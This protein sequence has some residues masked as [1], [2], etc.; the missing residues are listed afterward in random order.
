MFEFIVFHV[1]TSCVSFDYAVNRT[2]ERDFVIRDFFVP[3]NCVLLT[4]PKNHETSA[5]FHSLSQVTIS[6][7]II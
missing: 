3:T 1:L 2:N 5:D 7:E 6:L 4:H